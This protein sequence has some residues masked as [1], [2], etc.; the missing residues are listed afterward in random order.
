MKY[1]ESVV[2]Y[3][4]RF[5][6]NCFLICANLLCRETIE[7]LQKIKAEQ[8]GG[9]AEV[10]ELDKV[11]LLPKEVLGRSCPSLDFRSGEIV[12]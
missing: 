10:V 2:A 7:K 9:Q 6:A 11:S 12:H 8:T 5:I 1:T 3:I 4:P